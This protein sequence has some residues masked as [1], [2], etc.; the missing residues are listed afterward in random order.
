MVKVPN[1]AKKKGLAE[2]YAKTVSEVV[3]DV[4]P[5]DYQEFTRFVENADKSINITPIHFI[6]YLTGVSLLDAS[7]YYLKIKPL[8]QLLSK[9]AALKS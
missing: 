9:R 5:K 7:D 2:F 8:E 6:V 4:A 3:S 1:R